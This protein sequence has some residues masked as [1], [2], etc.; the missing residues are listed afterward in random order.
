MLCQ[1]DA[2]ACLERERERERIFEAGLGFFHRE[3]S[4]TKKELLSSDE[5]RCGSVL[6]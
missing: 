3:P 2:L 1:K 6:D 5:G 4:Q